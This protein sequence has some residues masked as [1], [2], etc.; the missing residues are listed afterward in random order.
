MRAAFAQY[1]QAVKAVVQLRPDWP[2]VDDTRQALLAHCLAGL[3]KF[4]CPRSIDFVD[5][6]P[7]SENGK[8]L[9]RVV[10]ERYRAA[11]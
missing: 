5:A 11:G 2:E 7:R 9:R 4:K 1:V 6:L 10:K 3:S 8:L